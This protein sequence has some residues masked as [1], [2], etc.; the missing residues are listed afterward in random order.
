[1][2]R[3]VTKLEKAKAQI[4]LDHPFFASILLKY[5]LVERKDIPTL[6]VDQRGQIYYN[7]DFVESLPVPQIVWGL[8]HEV[9]HRVGQ[10]AL[11][12]GRRDH[13]KWNY[14]GDAWINDTLDQCDV[15]QRIPNTVDM[16]G[17]AQETVENIYAKLPD[18]GK[19][20]GKGGGSG[21][22]P[23]AGDGIGEDI[24]NEGNPPSESEAQEI[25]ARMKIDIAEAA[26]AAKMKGKLPGVLAKIVADTIE[27]KTPWYDILERFMTEKATFDQS[28]AKPNRRYMSQDLYMPSMQSQAAM[29]E[30]VIQVDI[31]GS[32]SMQE[33]KH[34]N[35]HMKRIIEQTRPQKVHVIYTDT[36]VQKYEAFE[37][38]EEVEITY[39]SGG[40]THMPSGFNWVNKNGVEP[41]A[42]ICLTDGYTDF[43]TPPDY[44][45]VWCISSKTVA[46]HGETVHFEMNE[47]R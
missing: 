27:S 3:Q 31:S 4:V 2:A 43:G 19:G 11:R 32:V 7:P 1:M 18:G 21:G 42:F 36:D 10:H 8:C 20:K 30:V 15:G 23:M 45:V 37:Q 34:Y 13:G 38:G 5:P 12:K 40:G 9:M 47:G 25:E 26:Q 22:N 17:S 33:I 44:P 41:A 6:A 46:T 24:L 29:G 28:W 39:H 35:G 16:K 14:A